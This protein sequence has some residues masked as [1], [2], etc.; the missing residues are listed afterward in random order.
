M[1][2]TFLFAFAGIIFITACNKDQTTVLTVS[3]PIQ[4]SR[5]NDVVDFT[6]DELEM[7]TGSFRPG[8]LPLF[9]S[10]NDTLIVQFINYRG[11]HLP[12]EILVEVSLEA[13]ESR[14]VTVSWIPEAEYPSFPDKTNIH[15]ARHEAPQKDLAEETRME[16]SKTEDISNVFQMEG[17]GWENENVGFR[18]YLD[19]RNGMD[20]FGKTTDKMVLRNVGLKEPSDV[21]EDF[22]FNISYHELS[23]WGMDVLK[24]GN[25]LG[26]GSIAMDIGDSLYRIG[27][28]GVGTYE[29]LYE[30]PLRSEFRFSFND[31]EANDE[32]Y[33]ITHYVSITAGEYAYKSTLFLQESK[34]NESFVTGIVNKLSDSLIEFEAGNDHLAYFTHSKQ[35]EDGSYLAMAIMVRKDEFVSLLETPDSGTG[36]TETYALKLKTEVGSPAIYRFYAFWERSDPS[37]KDP[38][39]IKSILNDYALRLENPVVFRVK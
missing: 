6:F 9:V 34:N 22:N 25:S 26:A 3:N 37:F 15:L 24:V 27:D 14:E 32:M 19:R 12:E 35:A 20:I 1:K 18:N 30:G 4:E 31:W 2:K 38:E 5:M 16:T 10:E 13:G 36:I 39:V 7:L 11:D 21:S 29:K 8:K 33:N 17:P 23:D 28:N